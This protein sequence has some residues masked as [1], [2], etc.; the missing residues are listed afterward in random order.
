MNETV[1][2][3]DDDMEI[4]SVY[5]KFLNGKG[6][7]T[8]LCGNVKDAMKV[9]H[10]EKVECIV[11]DV[12]MPEIDGFS[13]FPKIRELTDAP[14]LFLTGKASEEDR[15]EGLMLGADDYIVKPCSLEELSLRIQINI[16][17]NTKILN[18]SDVIEFT[19]LKVE[20]LTQNVTIR[21]E[22]ILLS[23][24]EYELLVLFVKNPMKVLTFEEIGNALNGSYIEEDRQ[25]VM[26]NVSR[27]RKRLDEH[28]RQGERIETV[29]GKG[30]IFKGN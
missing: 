29:W 8:I 16:R 22:K 19:P 5:G 11:M 14:I 9:L 7:K 6:F 20:L 18:Q 28:L 10:K 3:I 15:I 24:R 21:N 1:L 25:S 23:K 12:M 30:Y 17:K 27:L 4:L 26:M 2:L 13:A